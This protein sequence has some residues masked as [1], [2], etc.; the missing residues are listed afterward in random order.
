MD[1]ATKCG[2]EPPSGPKGLTY[3]EARS[4]IT[5]RSVLSLVDRVGLRSKLS[6]PCASLLLARWAMAHSRTQYG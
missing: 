4:R 5:V 6:L 1:Y 3:V 2:L